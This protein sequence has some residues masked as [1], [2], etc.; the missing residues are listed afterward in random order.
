VTRRGFNHSLLGPEATN[1]HSTERQVT[2]PRSKFTP[3][4]GTEKNENLYASDHG[5]VHKPS[6]EAIVSAAYSM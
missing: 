4:R 1:T 3:H 6:K 5:N 2:N